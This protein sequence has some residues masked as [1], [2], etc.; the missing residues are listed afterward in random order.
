MLITITLLI[1][2]SIYCYLIKYKAKKKKMA[3][4]RHKQ[5]INKCVINMNSND[6]LKENDIKIVRAIISMK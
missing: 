3:I 4:L 5:Q 2:F 1:P 6:E